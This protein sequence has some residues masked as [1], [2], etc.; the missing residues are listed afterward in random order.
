MMYK[1]THILC[2]RQKSFQPQKYKTPRRKTRHFL[3]SFGIESPKQKKFFQKRNND[4]RNSLQTMLKARSA[5]KSGGF[6]GPLTFLCQPA[7][8]N[9]VI[10]GRLGALPGRDIF[11]EYNGL[12]I[13]SVL[14][15]GLGYSHGIKFCLR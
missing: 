3:K 11:Y 14:L 8:K 12:N 6:H 13:L 5:T 10:R 7:T 15:A 1:L 9:G 2:Y 4:F